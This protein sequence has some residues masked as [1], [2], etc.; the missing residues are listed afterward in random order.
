M[1]CNALKGGMWQITALQTLAW[2]G[3]SPLQDRM[4]LKSTKWLHCKWSP[5]YCRSHRDFFGISQLNCVYGLSDQ[6]GNI[7]SHEGVVYI[8]ASHFYLGVCF[9]WTERLLT[10][11]WSVFPEGRGLTSESNHS[12]WLLSS[13]ST[14]LTGKGSIQHCQRVGPIRLPSFACYNI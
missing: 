3:E 11:P 7:P 8:A 4:D 14:R 12:S 5:S 13:G 6:A 2:K 10:F 1:F 9:H